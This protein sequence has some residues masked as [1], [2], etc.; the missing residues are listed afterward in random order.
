MVHTVPVV[1]E[2]VKPFAQTVAWADVYVSARLCSTIQM[3]IADSC[4]TVHYLNRP[5][6][7]RN[8]FEHEVKSI[9]Y[10]LKIGSSMLLLPGDQ[11]MNST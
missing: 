5:V 6:G 7:I 8:D 1:V 2:P 9:C 3:C 4:G 10:K 11:L